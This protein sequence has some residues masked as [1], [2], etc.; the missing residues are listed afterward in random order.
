MYKKTFFA[1]AILAAVAANAQ[2]TAAPA[3]APAAAPVPQGVNPFSGKPLSMESRQR[4]LEIAKM[5]TS[6]LEEQL[7]QAS[8]AEDMAVM[9]LKKQVETAQATTARMKE[10]MLQKEV[11]NAPKLAAIQAA[12]AQKALA[13]MPMPVEARVKARPAKK[14]KPVLVEEAPV[15]QVAPPVLPPRVEVTTIMNFGGTR[16][17]VLDVDGNILT[18]KH[19]DNT[20]VGTVEILD[21]VSIRVGGR[22]YKVH[23]A[24]LARVV[25]S[26]PKPVDPKA[27]VSVPV[28]PAPTA[29]LPSGPSMATFP[30]PVGQMPLGRNGQPSL[31]PLQLP[32]GVTLLPATA[33]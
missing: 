17:A 5:E 8:L 25:I 3:A 13:P 4:A 1:V 14:V 24:T 18:V 22:T 10:E 7:K 23:G 28:A 16:A 19:G 29:T 26:D 2:P 32:A 30:G 11:I 31:P 27:P 20:P 12:N 6:L 21:D 15:K 33:N 9:P